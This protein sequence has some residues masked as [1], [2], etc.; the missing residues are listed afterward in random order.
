MS[1]YVAFYLRHDPCSMFAATKKPGDEPGFP[2]SASHGA[3]MISSSD[4]SRLAYFSPPF[5]LQQQASKC[6]CLPAAMLRPSFADYI[7]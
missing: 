3:E 1:D 7:C 6:L 5:D 2:I 4:I